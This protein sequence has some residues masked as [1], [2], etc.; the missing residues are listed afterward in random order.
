MEVDYKEFLLLEETEYW[1][2]INTLHDAETDQ[3]SQ[4]DNCSAGIFLPFTTKDSLNGELFL[5][6]R[7]MSFFSYLPSIE[8]KMLDSQY[9]YFWILDS[10]LT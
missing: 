10:V 3:T 8:Q 2:M 7:I 5:L 9:T 1:N 6:R 4:A